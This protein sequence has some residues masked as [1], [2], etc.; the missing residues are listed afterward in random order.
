MTLGSCHDTYQATSAPCDI[1]VHRYRLSED[2]KDAFSQEQS[3]PTS[4]QSKDIGLYHTNASRRQEV[5][6]H[7]RVYKPRRTHL[8]P[9]PCMP[10]SHDHA[11]HCDGTAD[12]SASTAEWKESAIVERPFGLDEKRWEGM[13]QHKRR[14]LLALWRSIELVEEAIQAGRAEGRE[15]ELP[16]VGNSRKT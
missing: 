16:G 6:G 4:A 15:A 5:E 3:L 12:R 11:S 14:Q 8:G 9:I 2:R 7:P 13:G 10:S 1:K